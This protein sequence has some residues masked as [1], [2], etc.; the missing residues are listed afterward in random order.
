KINSHAGVRSDLFKR[1]LENALITD[2]FGGVAQVE[3]TPPRQGSALPPSN[4]PTSPSQPDQK[5]HRAANN[6]PSTPHLISLFDGWREM[7]TWGS[8]AVMGVL[9]G[10]VSLRK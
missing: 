4:S 7:R 5:V 8:I 9:I 10:W 3:V 1:P 2:F 6:I